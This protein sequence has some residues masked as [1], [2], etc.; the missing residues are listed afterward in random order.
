MSK[1]IAIQIEGTTCAG[2]QA[3]IESA[4]SKLE[5]VQF[6]HADYATGKSTVR[7]DD[8]KVSQTKILKTIDKLGYRARKTNEEVVLGRSASSVASRFII[9]GAL[10]VLF[11]AGYMLLNKSG[12]LTLLERLSERN[13]SYGLIVAIG[14]LSSF[15]CVGMCGG[16]VLTYTARQGAQESKPGSCS[17]PHLQY[18]AG[19]VI[20]YTATGAIL[21]SF[22]SFF[23]ISPAFTGTV[24]LLAAAFMVLMGMS[25]LTGWKWLSKFG[26]HM[27]AF[28]GRFLYGQ[29]ASANPRTPLV[30]GLLNGLM[31]CGPLQAMQLYA[32]ASGS[33]SRG[34]LSM[35]AYALGTVPMMFGLG[36]VLSFISRERT[37]QML[38]V[39]GA[40]VIA[41]GVL[42]FSRGLANFAFVPRSSPA[43]A[44]VVQPTPNASGNAVT[45]LVQVVHMKLTRRGYEPSTLQAKA[46]V[47][48]RWVIDVVEMSGCTNELIMPEY[49]IDKK[50][51]YGENVI[52]FTPKAAGE[53]K[54]SCWM[55]MVW[56][57]F[58]VTS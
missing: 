12:A 36:S 19:R 18:N 47:P 42:M 20:S 17:L 55:R 40:I 52:E 26:L 1:Q 33:T 24:T 7:F 34:A 11:L 51:K 37:R 48:V 3:R 29:S 30:I 45:P 21:G 43:V 38:R 31:P 35:A 5:G 28:L 57:K 53:I 22:G 46:G 16:L 58:V 50:F 49:G 25:L 41:L 8:T 56:G 54:F 10:L 9:G 2:C 15:H 32:L 4:V 27:P 14:L 6:V 39:S 44:Q 13:L 23:A